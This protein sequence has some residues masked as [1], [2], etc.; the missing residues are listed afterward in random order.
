M[1]ARVVLAVG[2]AIL[3]ALLYALSN[4]LEFME[5]EHVPDEYA[6]H[7]SSRRCSHDVTG[8]RDRDR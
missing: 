4:V 6:L 7:L 2:P 1:S 3:T 8:T 5:A